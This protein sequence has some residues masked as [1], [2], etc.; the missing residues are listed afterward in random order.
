MI[1]PVHP[2]FDNTGR[3][4]CLLC[5]KP[6]KEVKV[7]TFKKSK[8]IPVSDKMKVRQK[9]KKKVY[10]QIEEKGRGTFCESCKRT[11]RLLSRS[12]ILSVKQYPQ[13]EALEE[14]IVIDCY[15]SSDCCHEI[16]ESR[17]YEKMIKLENWQH[18][19]EVILKLAP[20][21]LEQITPI[22]QTI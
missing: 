15:G 8:P 13:Y 2:S 18:R 14:N 7:Y 4:Y 21:F 11:D 6:E 9:A 17:D 20:S 12:H 3:S 1:C 16:Y 22:K 5:P 19:V 10:E